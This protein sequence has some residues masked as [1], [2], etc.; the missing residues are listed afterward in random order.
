MTQPPEKGDQCPNK[1]EQVRS[2]GE[3][4]A[5]L[6][7]R[8]QRKLFLF[9]L[10]LV[11]NPS[12]AEDILQQTN[13]VLWR[14]FDEFQP[15]TDF[16]KWASR[17]AYYEVLKFREQSARRPGQLSPAVLELLAART[18]DLLAEADLR[19]E[20]LLHCLAKLREP[21]R[22]MIQ[23]R[24]QVGID[25]RSVAETLGKSLEA[26]RRAIHRA[27]VAL[28]RCIEKKLAQQS[29]GRAA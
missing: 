13:L 3:E 20:A 17:V 23:L 15:G 1:E 9:I 10:P 11:G 24:Y 27:R 16:L 2:R 22:R 4:F 5:A 8:I 7:G 14:K 6:V 29:P 28:L 26:T 19:R 25:T 21:L 12:D 18:P